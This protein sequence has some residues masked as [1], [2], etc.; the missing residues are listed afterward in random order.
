VADFIIATTP[1]FATRCMGERFCLGDATLIRQRKCKGT[2]W[3]VVLP[4]SAPVFGSA[5]R[6]T[7][8]RL[9]TKCGPPFA[10]SF[11]RHDRIGGAACRRVSAI[12]R[13]QVLVTNKERR[14]TMNGK[15]LPFCAALA[16]AGA[17]SVSASAGLVDVVGGATSVVLDTDT[18]SSAAN[19]D[20]SSVSPDVGM[21]SLPNSVAFGINPRDAASLPTTFSYDPDDFLGAFSGTIEHTGSVFFNN[22]TIEVGNFTIGF[23]AA[24]AGTLGGLASGFFVESTVGIAAILFDIQNPDTLSATS[25]DLTIGA[26]LLVSPEFGTFLFDNGFSSSNLQGADVGD[27]LVEATAIPVPGALAVFALAGLAPRRRRRSA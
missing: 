10:M 19:L 20:L 11:R 14:R 9:Q 22:D 12:G 2:I 4:E 23:D 7:S 16:A 17:I 15:P 18:L 5:P 6:A 25:T 21:G 8:K 26:D 1:V 27:A 13:F 24:R 3:T